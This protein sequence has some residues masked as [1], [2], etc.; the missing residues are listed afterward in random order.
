MSAIYIVDTTVFLNIL[1]VPEWNQN[2]DTVL[3]DF[4]DRIKAG[5]RFH[6]PVAAI[7]QTGTHIADI[8]VQWASSQVL[9]S[10]VPRYGRESA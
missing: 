10:K 2:R 3:A 6:L 9:R 5:S 1:D 8:R 7:I 4:E